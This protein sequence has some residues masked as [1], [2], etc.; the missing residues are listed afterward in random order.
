MVQCDRV[1]AASALLGDERRT[2]RLD[3]ACASATEAGACGLTTWL[4]GWDASEG[5]ALARAPCEANTVGTT[6]GAESLGWFACTAEGAAALSA[7]EGV[8]VASVAS[9]AESATSCPFS[10]KV[11]SVDGVQ[12]WNV[13]GEVASPA[14]LRVLSEAAWLA[15]ASARVTEASES[16]LL[17]HASFAAAV[18]Q[19]L[20]SAL[21]ATEQSLGTSVV[22]RVVAAAMSRLERVFGARVVVGLVGHTLLTRQAA[23]GAQARAASQVLFERSPAA[24]ARSL[25]DSAA[26]ATAVG[27][28]T[29]Y[30][31]EEIGRYQIALWV[32]VVLA[33]IVLA[34]IC[35]VGTIDSRDPVL[36]SKFR[37]DDAHLH[38][39]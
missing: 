13:A 8:R 17:L 9:D 16:P 39:D 6:A 25:A 12:V 36:Y 22:E 1:A 29:Q 35:V 23:L 33:L 28:A 10:F 19:L 15:A 18:E 24:A 14:L 31:S 11:G 7:V 30:T 20:G 32:S 38:G 26:P 34:T 5:L 27:N 37:R 2:V 3:R 4:Y 21:P